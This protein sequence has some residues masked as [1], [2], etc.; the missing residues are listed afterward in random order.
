MIKCAFYGSLR[1]P[2]YNYI[3]MCQSFGKDSMHYKKTIK[4]F[5]YEMYILGQYPGIKDSDR[6]KS[7]VVDLFEINQEVFDCV[8]RMEISSNFYEDD[9]KIDEHYYKIFPYAGKVNE[10]HLV[11]SGDWVS[12]LNN[13]EKTKKVE[14]E[15]HY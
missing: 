1:R 4:L 14:N 6:S 12:L 7:I 2:M 10:S 8:Y 13:I 3:R 5:G 11:E 9:I 15:Q